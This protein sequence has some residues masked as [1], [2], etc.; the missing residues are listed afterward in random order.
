MEVCGLLHL[1][2]KYPSTYR[3]GV[4]VSPTVGLDAVA[5]RYA[6]I[7]EVKAITEYVNIGSSIDIW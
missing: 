7:S 4:W 3:M 1:R 5:K 2:G 6:Q